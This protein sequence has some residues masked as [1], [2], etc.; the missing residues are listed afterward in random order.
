MEKCMQTDLEEHYVIAG[1]PGEF[2]LSHVT[3]ETGT[4][5]Y[6]AQSIYKAVKDIERESNSSIIGLD[7]AATM[8]G[9]TRGCIA[10][11]EPLLQRPLQW[12]TSL[13]H[14]N[15]LPLRHVFKALD[16]TTKSPDSFPG[17]IGSHLNG[18]VSDWKVAN[19]KS[20]YNQNF[21]LVPSSVIDELSADQYYGY[22]ICMAV[23]MGPSAINKDLE[24]L[25]VG[26]LSHA[27]SLTL[28]CRILQYYI[29]IKH[30]S[31]S[32]A[33]LAEFCI[34]VYFPNWF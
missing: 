15:E 29:S 31:I 16:G 9:P 18:I 19:F 28:A 4:G 8:T 3:P 2:Y 12:V 17:V 33:T 11:L 34:K 1:E 13:L 32:L 30:P 14:C 26:G 25:E 6:I 27:R 20:I 10:S 5:L 22:R 24:L 21:P 7:G 23:M